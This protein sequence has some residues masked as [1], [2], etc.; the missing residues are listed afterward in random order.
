MEIPLSYVPS[1]LR[2]IADLDTMRLLVAPRRVQILSY[3]MQ[4]PLTVKEVAELIGVPA[5]RLYYHFKLLEAGG[6]ITVVDTQK[7]A[8]IMEKRY[9]ASASNYLVDPALLEEDSPVRS[10]AVDTMLLNTLSL[11]RQKLLTSVETG[12]V[13]LSAQ[14]PDQ[15]SLLLRRQELCLTQDMAQRLY[16]EL[17]EL[18]KKYS[19]YENGSAE[20]SYTLTTA[21]FPNAILQSG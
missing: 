9:R 4:S 7:V 6:L 2:M 13:D 10:A 16:E 17:D 5:S 8:G 3:L 12:M 20:Q 14:V 21:L 15:R 18:L 11:T 19:Q 1:D